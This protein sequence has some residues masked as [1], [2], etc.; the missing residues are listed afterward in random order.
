ME[1]LQMKLLTNSW[2]L[3]AILHF[4]SKGITNVIMH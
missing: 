3:V 1:K 4:L 2:N